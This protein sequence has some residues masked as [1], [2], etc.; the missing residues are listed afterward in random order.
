VAL[1]EA[2][3]AEMQN[4]EKAKATKMTVANLILP[5]ATPS[6]DTICEYNRYITMKKENE[7]GVRASGIICLR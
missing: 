6:E 2:T 1:A 7:R 4:A 5:I 3:F